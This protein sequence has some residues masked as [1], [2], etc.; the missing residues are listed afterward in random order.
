[1]RERKTPPVTYGR[2]HG[3]LISSKGNI[4]KAVFRNLSMHSVK[5]IRFQVRPYDWV[6][7]KNVSLRPGQKTAVK[8]VSFDD[9][10]APKK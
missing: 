7:F 8:V 4:G 2:E 3:S 6:E 9:F 1:V 10:V 5:E